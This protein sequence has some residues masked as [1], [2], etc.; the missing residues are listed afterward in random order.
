[1]LRDLDYH[2]EMA[3]S[4]PSKRMPSD[5][6][7]P[8]RNGRR[9]ANPVAGTW[10]AEMGYYLDGHDEASRLPTLGKADW[11]LK[12]ARALQ[13]N[14]L[15]VMKIANSFKTVP[16]HTMLVCV[17]LN[18]YFDAAA[19]CW[20]VDEFLAFSQYDGRPKRWLIVPKEEIIRLEPHLKECVE[21]G[22]WGRPR[23]GR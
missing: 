14:P 5:E 1:M 7:G 20:G 3:K 12:N 10:E 17:V 21:T 19:I 8:M 2:E 15:G 18:G 22:D 9:E 6:G 23:R 16:E 4:R 13:L 11:L